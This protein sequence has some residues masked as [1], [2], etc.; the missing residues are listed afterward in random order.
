MVVNITMGMLSSLVGC[1]QI[2]MTYRYFK[3]I[4]TKG[5]ETTSPFIMVTLWSSLIF[6]ITILLMGIALAF[7]Q[8]G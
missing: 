7:G 4:K 3:I 1:L 8:F 2:F 6:G 5:D